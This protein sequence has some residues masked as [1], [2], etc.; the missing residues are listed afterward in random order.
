M[1]FGVENIVQKKSVV[2]GWYYLLIESLGQSK[3]MRAS[4]SEAPAVNAHAP[5]GRPSCSESETMVISVQVKMR[6]MTLIAVT[7]HHR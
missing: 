2:N 4:E 5:D 3:H 7:H 1:S 6:V